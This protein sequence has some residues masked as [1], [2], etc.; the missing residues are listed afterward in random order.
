MMQQGRE[1]SLENVRGKGRR[2]M[3]SRTTL[4]LRSS[5]DGEGASREVFLR[6]VS[7]FNFGSLQ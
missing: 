4:S 7:L 2:K 6:F 5:L 1:S 3:A